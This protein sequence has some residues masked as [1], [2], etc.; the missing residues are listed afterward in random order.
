MLIM[1]QDKNIITKIESGF[2]IVPAK[3]SRK[4]YIETLDQGLN[5]AT[6]DTLERAQEVLEQLFKQYNDTM[7]DLIFKFPE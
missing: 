6:Y 7:I 1:S 3:T 2:R 4:Y 5:F